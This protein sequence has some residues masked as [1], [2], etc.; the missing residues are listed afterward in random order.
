MNLG[1]VSGGNEVNGQ[2]LS[3]P[4]NGVNEDIA[5]VTVDT[6][7]GII[8]FTGAETGQLVAAA[9]ALLT[10]GAG[11]VLLSRR[12]RLATVEKN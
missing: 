5:T 11:L 6:P 10:L 4:V 7:P 9:L 2:P 3:S 12:R 8:A 1:Q